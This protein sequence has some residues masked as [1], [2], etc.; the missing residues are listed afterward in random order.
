[1]DLSEAHASTFER[2]ERGELNSLQIVLLAEIERFN[3]LLRKAASSLTELGKGI[4]G[5]VIMSAELDAMFSSMLRNQVPGNW[6]KVAYPSL[7]PLSSW[8]KDLTR[9]VGF[10]RGWLSSGQPSCFALPAFFFPQVPRRQSNITPKLH[11]LMP[12]AH[13]TC[14]VHIH[15]HTADCHLN[16]QGFMTGLLQMHA[17]RYAIPIDSLTFSYAIR[18]QESGAEIVPSEVPSDGVLIDGFFLEGA[19]WDRESRL[20]VDSRQGVIRD[21]FPVVHFMPA[22]DFVR[23]PSDYEC[24]LYKTAL[25]AGVLSTTGQSTNYILAVSASPS[26]GYHAQIGASQPSPPLNSGGRTD[27]GARRQVGE[28]GSRAP[29]RHRR[30]RPR[31]RTAL[32]YVT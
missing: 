8:T 16:A 6:A 10:M 21:A 24:P 2:N 13:A 29:L 26:E 31:S 30:L 19:R 15:A 25:R 14:H 23:A 17:R 18:S 12:H 5:L 22:Q 27:Q 20:L 9:R 28:G 4:S 1:M 32:Y 11:L 7:K 3:R